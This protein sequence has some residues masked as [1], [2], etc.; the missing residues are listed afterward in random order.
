[1]LS[2]GRLNWGSGK[3]SSLTEQMA[4]QNDL[5]TLHDEWLEALEIIPRMWREDVFS[6]QGHFFNI[7]PT[8]V[9]PKPV[10]QPHPPMFAACSKP[11]RTRRIE[12]CHRFR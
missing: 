1:V 2:N 5:S 7:P 6:F 3:S 8:Q 4:F 11:D 9:I 12:F 10:Q